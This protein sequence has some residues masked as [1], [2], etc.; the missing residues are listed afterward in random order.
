MTKVNLPNLHQT[1]VNIFLITN[2]NNSNNISFELASSHTRVTS[3]KF[4]KRYGVSE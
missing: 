2:F 4:T 1:V 3:I